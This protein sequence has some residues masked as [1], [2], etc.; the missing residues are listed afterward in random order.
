MGIPIMNRPAI[1]R[2]DT[3]GKLEG[4]TY[5][6]YREGDIP[7]IVALVDA[8]YE[9]G[10][11][12]SP[13]SEE[14]LAASYA[15]PFS[16]PE[17]QVILA[18]GSSG[19]ILGY[20]R[21]VCFDDAAGDERLYQMR[22][23]VHP[24]MQGQGLEQA[25]A[26][27][28]MDNIRANERDPG[29]Q[30]RGKVSL[31]ALSSEKAVPEQALLEEIGLR[32]VRH[33]WTMQRALDLPIAE[34]A[35]VE[36]VSARTYRRPEDN[37]A[38][39]QAYNNSF[40]DHFEF[41]ALTQEMIDYQIGRPEARPDL[42]W[43]AEIEVEPGKLAGF[44]VCDINEQ[45]NAHSGNKEGWIAELGTVRGWRGIGLG[46]SLLLRGMRS[47]KEAGMNTA[48]LGVDSESLTGANRLYESVG[49]TIRHH[50][51]LYKCELSEARI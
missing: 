26:A 25:L 27:R 49:F 1:Q 39:L 24:G 28:M 16:Y 14:G 18:V 20:A 40:I 50:H 32:P 12:D 17:R 23:L 3:N 33:A 21:A 45:E 10:Y 6:F 7:A 19:A 29:L 46:R 31:L 44:C 34:P 4:L 47:L 43:V 51:T 15:Q 13:A 35:E 38:V 30:P 36:G 5:R 8:A 11:V 22:A 41:H 48:L 42:S 37:A 2:P 9:V